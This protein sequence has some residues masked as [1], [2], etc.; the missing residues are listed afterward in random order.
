MIL[1]SPQ[2]FLQLDQLLGLDLVDKLVALFEQLVIELS[3]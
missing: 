2:L 1:L 3:A